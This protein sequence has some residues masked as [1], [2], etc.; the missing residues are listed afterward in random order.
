MLLSQGAQ[1]GHSWNFLNLRHKKVSP[2]PHPGADALLV[3]PHAA[4]GW[5]QMLPGREGAEQLKFT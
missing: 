1:F 5:R 4:L 3:L 2:E